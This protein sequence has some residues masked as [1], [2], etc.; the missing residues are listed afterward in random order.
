[1]I[2]LY[3]YSKA[4]SL[5]EVLVALGL[6]AS[7][8]LGLIAVVIR[9]GD[10]AAFLAERARIISTAEF[11]A[12]NIASLGVSRLDPLDPDL[13]KIK[14]FNDKE[15]QVKDKATL[16]DDMDLVTGCTKDSPCAMSEAI[17]CTM[18]QAMQMLKLGTHSNDFV[19][20]EFN[21]NELH[22]PGQLVVSYVPKSKQAC[23]SGTAVCT[24]RLPISFR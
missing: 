12:Q 16:C 2:S 10:D 8:M 20:L 14:D 18:V 5:V 23:I 4:F 17:G 9:A 22:L 3:R 21:A 24:Y 11:I 7:I 19:K 6:F 1:M 13:Q 15:F